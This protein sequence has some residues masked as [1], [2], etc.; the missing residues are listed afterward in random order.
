MIFYRRLD[1]RTEET[2]IKE[3]KLRGEPAKAW[4]CVS[5]YGKQTRFT[6]THNRGR[7]GMQ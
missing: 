1:C 5:G 6:E 7:G 2:G 3:N 4:V